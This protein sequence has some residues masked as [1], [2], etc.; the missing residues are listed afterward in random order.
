MPDTLK[1]VVIVDGLRVYPE[2]NMRCHWSARRRRFAEQKT[3]VAA[4]LNR[5]GAADRDELRQAAA[6][7]KLGVRMVRLGGRTIDDDNLSSGFKAVRDQVAAYLLQDDG[8]K[9]VKYTPDQESGGS[10]AIRLE[11]ETLP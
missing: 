8:N 5:I 11:L 10:W 1:V 6:G 7:G 9:K 2:M 4:M 3:M